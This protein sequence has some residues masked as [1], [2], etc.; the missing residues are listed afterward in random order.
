MSTFV[1]VHPA[2]FGGWCWKK[3]ARPLRASG[4]AVHAPTLTGLGER[5]HLASPGVGL[6]THIEDVVNVLTFEDLNDVILVGNSSAGTVITGVADR[7]PERIDQVVYLDAFLPSDGQSTLD[8][9]PPDRRP[10]MERLVESEGDG[11]LLPRFAAAPWEEFVPDAWQVTDEAD[12]QW[13]LARLRPTPFGHFTEPLQL[14]RSEVEQPRRVYIRC[15][16]WPHPGFDRYAA[17]AQSSPSWSCHE[18]ATS[19]LPYITDPDDV[20]AVLLELAG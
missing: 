9:V 4:H 10:A 17:A 19:H 18:L 5:A 3:V 12:L 16:G 20:T 15:R 2:W 13:V 6:G 14:R 8:L 11:W 1:L 7:V